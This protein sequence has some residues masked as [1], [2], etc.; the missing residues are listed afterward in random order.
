VL[1]IDVASD[2]GLD[3]PSDLVL[4][5]HCLGEQD[6]ALRRGELGWRRGLGGG[7]RGQLG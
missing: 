1:E 7:E 6:P 5:V 2:R 4:V 3:Q